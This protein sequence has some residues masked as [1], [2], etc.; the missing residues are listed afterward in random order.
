MTIAE[1]T[2]VMGRLG[3]DEAAAAGTGATLLAAYGAVHRHYHSLR[4]L[5][6]VVAVIDGLAD[7]AADPDL[8]RLAAWYHDAVHEPDGPGGDEQRSAQLA[9]IDLTGLGLGPPSVDEVARLVEL[10]AT[11]DPA[12]DDRNGA[13]LCDADLWILGADRDRYDRYATEVR[14]EYAHVADGAWRS[15]R[16]AVL[17]HFLDRA[18][19]YST[20]P[21]RRRA[22]T[23]R[24]NLERELRSFG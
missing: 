5:G 1:W 23:A 2:A 17:R 18:A 7:L 15:G 10:T 16:A 4:H 6:A 13:V 24:A 14:A 21:G 9:R 19:I 12:P 20:A 8:V 22:S 11:H 3:V